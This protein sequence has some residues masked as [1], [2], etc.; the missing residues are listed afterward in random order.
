[1][2]EVIGQRGDAPLLLVVA[3]EENPC[4]EEWREVIVSR[5]VWGYGH[6]AV[7][8]TGHGPGEMEAALIDG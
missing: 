7:A 2:G 5:R 4:P 1:M 3:Q 6:G 8:V